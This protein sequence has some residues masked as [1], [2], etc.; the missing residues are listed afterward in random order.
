VFDVLM[1]RLRNESSVSSD[2]ITER[3]LFLYSQR[4]LDSKNP[5]VPLSN[6]FTL[7]PLV[8]LSMLPCFRE[9]REGGL[10]REAAL[11]DKA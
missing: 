11:F 4:D 8:A 7:F 1:R 10:H 3:L 9:I 6:Q 2:G 5:V